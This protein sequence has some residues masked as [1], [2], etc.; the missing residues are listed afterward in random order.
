MGLS[1]KIMIRE[2]IILALCL[3]L[4]AHV[5]LGFLLHGEQNWPIESYGYYGIFFGVFIYVVV[6]I[7]RSLWWL[8]K[9]GRSTQGS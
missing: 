9:G 1:K 7:G 4:G 2:W 3:G 6:Q 8:K 5:A